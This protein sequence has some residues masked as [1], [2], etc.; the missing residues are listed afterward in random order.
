MEQL[1]GLLPSSLLSTL[2]ALAATFLGLAAAVQILQESYKYLSWTEARVYRKVLLD[3][4]GPWI[5]KLFEPGVVNDLAVRGPFQIRSLR[6]PGVLLPLAQDELRE[7]A[8]RLA[9]TWVRRLVEQLRQERELQTAASGLPIWSPAWAAL[10]EELRKVAP[11]DPT[12]GDAT[13]ILA[14]LQSWVQP[15]GD[16]RQLDARALL[17]AFEQRFLPEVVRLEKLFPRLERNLQYANRRRNLRH[18]FSIALLLAV[19]F[20]LPF[21]ELYESASRPSLEESVAFAQT[22]IDAYEALAK[23]EPVPAGEVV[24]VGVSREELETQLRQVLAQPGEDEGTPLFG[25]AL[26]RLGKLRNQSFLA[27]PIHLLYCLVTAFLVSFGAPLWHNLTG[28]L[29]RAG[30]ARLGQPVEG[31]SPAG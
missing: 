8:E 17:V 26:E 14:F 6:P 22:R 15:A 16:A 30:R 28:A 13:E 9:P 19:G 10:V 24:G 21:D 20:D 3:F 18:T 23:P 2:L 1:A 27:L 5:Q 4:A 7:A 31:A 12:H 25:R 11:D 29:W